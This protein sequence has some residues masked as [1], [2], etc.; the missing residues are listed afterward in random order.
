[1]PNNKAFQHLIETCWDAYNQSNGNIQAIS[2]Y[3]GT[4]LRTEGASREEVEEFLDYA[5]MSGLDLDSTTVFN[6]YGNY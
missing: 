5:A 2:E 1:M 3:A 6:S 4:R